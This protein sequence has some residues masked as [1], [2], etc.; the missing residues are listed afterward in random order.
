MAPL[1]LPFQMWV[2]TVGMTCIGCLYWR[3]F[4]WARNLA[5]LQVILVS[6]GWAFSQWPY[7]VPPNLTVYDAAPQN[8][9]WNMATILSIGAIPLIPAYVWLMRVFQSD[10]VTSPMK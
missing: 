4:L 9:L 3:K 7:V 1:S 10:G 5:V 2:G 8:V 6:A